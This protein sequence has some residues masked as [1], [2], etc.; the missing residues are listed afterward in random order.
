[1]RE[2]SLDSLEGMYFSSLRAEVS[3]PGVSGPMEVRGKAGH[4]DKARAKTRVLQDFTKA[5]QGNPWKQSR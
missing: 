2:V 5:M 4:A 1:M 3:I